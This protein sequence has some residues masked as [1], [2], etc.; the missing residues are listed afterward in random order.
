MTFNDKQIWEEPTSIGD[1]FRQ[2]Y[3]DGIN[4]YIETKNKKCRE[5]RTKFMSPENFKNN[6]EDFRKHFISMIG[7]KDFL[8]SRV[9][10][11]FLSMVGS[12]DVCNIY[13]LVVKITPEIPFYSLLFIPKNIL[14]P[15]PLM[16]AQH[17]GGGTPELCSDFY[18]KNNYNH[19][20]QRAINRGYAV[21]APQ[22]LVWSQEEIETLRAHNIPYNRKQLDV[23]FKR[24]GESITAMEISGI[25]KSLDYVCGMSEIDSDR[26]SMMGLSYGGYFTLLTTAIDKRIKS[27]YVAGVFNDRDKY[28]WSDWCYF[29]SAT[30]FQDAEVAA[31]CAPRK[32]Y[33]QVGK[34]DPVFDYHFA[35]TEF[36][37]LKM[38]YSA[39]GKEKNL[40]FSLWEGGHTI[41]DD[42][43]GYEF[44]S[45]D[46]E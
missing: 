16:V 35:I 41:S 9:C 1:V 25:I 30:M 32:L 43:F 7:I 36:E 14:A 37:R 23:D 2:N 4:K 45:L 20:V 6:Q 3:I 42:D 12:D 15:K 21:L 24:F 13:R 38:Y 40:H 11:S 5:V 34:A 31:L 29:N 28:D 10:S 22:I 17:G 44:I 8:N 39:L 19:M 27:A 26:I 33:I 18:G 46:K